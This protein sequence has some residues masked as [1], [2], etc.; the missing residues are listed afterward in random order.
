MN[1]NFECKTS[2]TFGKE[3]HYL[4]Q[5]DFLKLGPSMHSPFHLDGFLP[6]PLSLKLGN[7]GHIPE[8]TQSDRKIHFQDKDFTQIMST[9]YK[10]M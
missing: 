10:L 5:L 9:I 4:L 6:T 2:L 1:Q 7:S 3:D 8:I